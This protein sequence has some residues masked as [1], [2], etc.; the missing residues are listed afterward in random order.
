VIAIDERGCGD[1]DWVT[2][3]GYS[4][5]AFATD[6]GKF[7]ETTGLFPFDYWGTSQGSRI[8]MPV[9]A[10]YGQY[11]DHL[12]LGD[13]GP[14]PDPSPAGKETAAAR[15]AGGPRAVKPK[16]FFGAQAAFN[17]HKENDPRAGD[18]DE[19][20]WDTVDNQ[21]RTNWDGILIP[22]TDPE[23]WWQNGRTALK[24]GDFMWHSVRNIS[25]KTLVLRGEISTV[26]DKEQA[27]EMAKAIPNGQ[28]TMAEVSKAGHGLFT[29]NM[30]HT[31]EIVRKFLAT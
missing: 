21:Y 13:Y 8:G 20:I 18:T 10:F 25:C 1:S 19:A 7:A 2:E 31:L 15:L 6:I 14:M 29:E 3:G 11:V 28:G 12:I 24:E 5:Q 23:M 4:A 27:E 17:W 30:D 22:K 16:G 26:L 9:G